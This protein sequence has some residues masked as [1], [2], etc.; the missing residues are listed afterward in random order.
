ME[1]GFST[2]AY[3]VAAV[4]FILSLGGLS[5][6]ESAKRAVWYGITGMGLAVFA[7][8]MGPGQ[9]NW[10]LSVALVLA[11]GAIGWVVAQRVQMTEMPQLV[12]AMH[13]L[14][15]LAAVFIGFNAEIEMVRIA[16]LHAAGDAAGIE[17]LKGFAQKVAHKTPAE[18]N[19]LKI[20]VFLGVFIG[21]VTF[22][23]SVIA[24]GKLAGKVTS[25]AVKLPGGHLLNA[26]AA[27][28]SLAL[29]VMYFNGAGS[30]TLIGMTLLAFFIGYH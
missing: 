8:L 26:A 17:A 22:T 15:G 1:Y 29:L 23:G 12:A 14:V 6:Q 21:A 10:A 28:G 4:L 24:F 7:T 30:W 27:A 2:A 16:A 25:K 11:G 13:S 18:I 9:G 5:G 19:I 20:E 3:V